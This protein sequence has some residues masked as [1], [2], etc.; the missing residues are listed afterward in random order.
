MNNAE[1]Y[2][3]ERLFQLQDLSY[4]DFNAKLIPNVDKNKVIGI[5][6]PNLRK[7]AKE[8]A[9]TEQGQE[10]IKILPHKYHEEN[11]LHSFIIEQ[12]K[13]YDK[14]VAEIDRFLPY[15]D[16]WSTCDCLSPKAFSKNKDRLI[17]E[18]KRWISDEKTFTIR[19][20]VGML[21]RYF[22][23]EAYDPIYPEMVAGIR[24]EEYYVNMMLAWYFATALA[25]QY[26]TVIPYLEEKSLSVW[27]HNKTIRKA[28]ESYRITKEQKD[29]LRT[30]TIK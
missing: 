22:L 8:L 9:N 15:I 16:N 6:T 20:G 19:F 1:E 4:R 10:F 2:I 28:I 14:C 23:D 21:M 7:L 13:D 30:L 3:R 18:I 17:T 5:R 12:I 27:V 26:E 25:K 29:Y 11:C 24:S